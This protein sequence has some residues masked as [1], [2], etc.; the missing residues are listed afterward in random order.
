MQQ[1][2]TFSGLNDNG[3]RLLCQALDGTLTMSQSNS[4]CGPP[5]S[6]IVVIVSEWSHPVS[7]TPLEFSCSM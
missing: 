6:P 2:H 1:V 4:S 7:F 5:Q 3:G